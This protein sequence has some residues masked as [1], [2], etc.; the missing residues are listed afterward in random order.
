MSIC[1]SIQTE[2]PS[3]LVLLAGSGV[4]VV[5]PPGIHLNE[6]LRL[7][8]CALPDLH[9]PVRG[10]ARQCLGPRNLGPFEIAA[11][12]DGHRPVVPQQIDVHPDACAV[13]DV[14][15]GTTTALQG[16]LAGELL[17]MQFQMCL[18]DWHP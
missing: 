2:H 14:P 8:L 12:T 3:R 9:C 16:T 7:S 4:R 10:P 17:P 11:S 15:R 6:N 18:Q 5:C 1:D 13:A